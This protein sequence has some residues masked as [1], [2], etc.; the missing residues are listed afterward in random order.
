MAFPNQYMVAPSEKK[1]SGSQ[2]DSR[3]GAG[4]AVGDGS[5]ARGHSD[6]LGAVDGGLRGL[7]VEGGH[8]GGHEAS[9]KD[10]G[11]HLDGLGSG[12][13]SGGWGGKTGLKLVACGFVDVGERVDDR[14]QR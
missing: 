2:K 10:H 12:V 8:C 7:A 9:S 14:G 3:R 13:V 5:S 6:E 4:R 1:R 11:T